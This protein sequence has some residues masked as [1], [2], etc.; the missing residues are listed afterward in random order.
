MLV[1]KKV[2][3]FKEL[4]A[5]TFAVYDSRRLE[6]VSSLLNVHMVSEILFQVL[7]GTRCHFHH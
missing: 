6:D 1:D 3:K 7:S 5:S 2:K 4:L